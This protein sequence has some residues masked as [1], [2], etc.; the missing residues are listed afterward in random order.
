MALVVVSVKLYHPF[1]SVK[2]YAKAATDL[3]VLMIDW[4][5]WCEEQKKYRGR[6]TS[7]GKLG[8][9]NEMR[10]KE[11]DVFRMSEEQLDEYLDWY[12]KTWV[13]E[14]EQ[15]Q[16][17]G[18]LPAELL[19]MFPTGRLDGSSSP[20]ID[21]NQTAE[22]EHAALDAK[23]KSVQGSLQARGVISEENE[24][25]S[26]GPVRRIGSFYKRYHKEEELPPQAKV[27]FEAAANLISVSLST[28]VLAVL[29][30]EQLLLNHRAKEIRESRANESD[31]DPMEGVE[32]PDNSREDIEANN[33]DRASLDNLLDS[34]IEARSELAESRQSDA[35]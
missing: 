26:K 22:A 29:Q 5:V 1:D 34:D 21:V 17:R 4:D 15:R 25:N 19:D 6:E 35:S 24:Q 3:G 14:G 10:V 28:M 23:L 2:R 20:A 7:D 32:E 16:R 18:D 12:E 8:R 13:K 9:G 27:F 30:T 11:Q 31:A 33:D